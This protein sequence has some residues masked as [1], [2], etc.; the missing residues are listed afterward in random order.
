MVT[1]LLRKLEFEPDADEIAG[2]DF[3]LIMIM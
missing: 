1:A 3:L 2:T